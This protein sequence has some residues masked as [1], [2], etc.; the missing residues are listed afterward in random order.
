MK[1]EHLVPI[2]LLFVVIGFLY[3]DSKYEPPAKDIPQ[4][5]VE[6]LLV[7]NIDGLKVIQDEQD[8]TYTTEFIKRMLKKDE[9]LYYAGVEEDEKQNMTILKFTIV[10]K[11]NP[12]FFQFGTGTMHKGAIEK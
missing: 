2:F 5:K 1:T 9:E 8:D 7:W 6:K 10:K 3:L 4:A 12:P 11:G